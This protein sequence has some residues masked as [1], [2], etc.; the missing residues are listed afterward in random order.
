MHAGQVLE[1]SPGERMVCVRSG[2]D[3]GPFVF[4]MELGPGKKGP[5]MHSHDEGDERITVTEGEI[6]FRLGS[7]QQHLHKGDVLLIP[8][9]APHTF[10]NPS[11]DTPVRCR[12]DHGSRFERAFDQQVEPAGFQRLAMFITFVDPGASRMQNPFVRLVLRLVAMVGRARRV[13]LL[14]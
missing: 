8:R 1:P 10:W 5:P 14:T 7:Q 9:G 3:G 4:D 11:K 12:V 6:V 13:Q 2:R